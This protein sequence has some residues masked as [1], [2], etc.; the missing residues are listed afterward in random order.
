[1]RRTSHLERHWEHCTVQAELKAYRWR[2]ST[3]QPGRA[4]HSW[5]GPLHVAIAKHCSTLAPIRSPSSFYRATFPP[6]TIHTLPTLPLSRSNPTRQ[7]QRQ[8]PNPQT[9]SAVPSSPHQV[10]IAFGFN[11]RPAIPRPAKSAAS[12]SK[13]RTH[14]PKRTAGLVAFDSPEDGASAR[15]APC[16]ERRDPGM[17]L[18]PCRTPRGPPRLAAPTARRT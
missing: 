5:P 4:D 10:M 12:V 11:D 9:T 16:G 1:M 6:L 8:K 18:R 3:I 14:R 7:P 13:V 17:F 2:F 15:V